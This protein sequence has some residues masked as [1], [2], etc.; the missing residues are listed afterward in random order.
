MEQTLSSDQFICPIWGTPA[1]LILNRGGNQTIVP[2]RAGGRYRITSNAEDML[3]NLNNQ[4]CAK[5]S[6]WI[7]NEHK[8]G[9]LEPEITS[10]LINNIKDNQPLSFT[11]KKENFFKFLNK[12]L[13]NFDFKLKISSPNVPSEINDHLSVCIE[14][15]DTDSVQLLE[16]FSNN[17]QESVYCN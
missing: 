13:P 8:S 2:N 5:L 3:K 15:I 16:F 6:T 17:A 1:I 7:L 9:N 12:K 11:K 10:Y 14:A 4:L